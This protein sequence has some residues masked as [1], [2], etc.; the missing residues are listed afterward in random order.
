[1]LSSPQHRLPT[2]CGSADESFG[3]GLVPR[4]RP[5]LLATGSLE[6]LE[7]L[8]DPRWLGNERDDPHLSSASAKLG[9]GFV[10][11]ADELG[12]LPSQ[13][14][15]LGPRHFVVERG[16]AGQRTMRRSFTDAVSRLMQALKRTDAE[17]APRSFR[18]PST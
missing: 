7:D 14:S 9:I 2:R 1:M 3:G 5:G 10:D 4:R 18:F 11:A 16:G 15:P 17:P 12:P 8:L 6:V 13:S